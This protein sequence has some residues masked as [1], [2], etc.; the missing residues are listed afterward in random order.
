MPTVTT[1]LDS[2]APIIVVHGATELAD[3]PGLDRYTSRYTVRFARD[4]QELAATL[5][6]AEILLGWDFAAADLEKA[7]AAADR[8]RW[9]HWSG[10]GVD[11][12]L[13]PA[14]CA[15]DVVLTNARGLFDR[16]IAEYVLGF[17]LAFAKRLPETLALQRTRT[18]SHRLTPRLEG[19]VVTLLGVGG[20]GRVTARLLKALGMKTIG[21]GRRT[22]SQDMDFDEVWSI[23]ELS[24]TLPRSDYLISSLPA[25]PQT[26]Q[27][28]NAT[29]LALLKPG[30][31]FVNVGRGH[32][33]DERALIAALKTGQLAGAALDVFT[34][35]PLPPTDP[36]WALDNVI[37]S[38][39]MSGDFVG[40][41]PEQAAVFFTNLERYEAG[42]PLYNE[43][44]KN[45]GY[46]VS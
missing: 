11:A 21:I 44:D 29:T 38:P 9:I 37:V 39:H 36:L 2:P 25:T 46:F 40:Y 26:K 41:E 31:Y 23:D 42:L 45:A 10:A 14:L 43:V 6:G 13:F 15:S 4:A 30:A 32:S 28:L 1:Q 33:V 18:W 35:E 12:A 19:Q 3:V 17:V 20:I 22:R 5:P 8:L 34:S 7:W 24:A 27:V 16:A